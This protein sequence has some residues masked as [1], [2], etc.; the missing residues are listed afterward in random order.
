MIYRTLGKTG[1]HP[2]VI[3]IG[4]WQFGGEWGVNFSQP[5]VD[6]IL[7]AAKRGA[8]LTKQ[9]LLFGRKQS[10]FSQRRPLDLNSL[11]TQVS[12]MGSK[13]NDFRQV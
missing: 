9:L 12:Q 2:S 1:L 3:G 5:E 8:Q 7:D 10:S 6:A 4:T 13:N 11:L